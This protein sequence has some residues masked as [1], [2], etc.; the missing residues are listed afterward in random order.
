MGRSVSRNYEAEERE[1]VY[2]A[3]HYAASIRC[4]VE[5]WKD[6]EE[7]NPKSKEKWSFID[8][9]SEGMKHRTKRCAEADR[10]RCVRCGRESKYMK[11]PGRCSGPK[12]LSKNLGKKAPSWRS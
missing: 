12:F 8:K 10:F 6:C 5:E 4:L 3:L 1:E 9:K 2:A 7:L 11:M